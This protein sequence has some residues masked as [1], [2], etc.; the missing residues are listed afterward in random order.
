MLNVKI[1]LRTPINTKGM[2]LR[3]PLASE[4]PVTRLPPPA[5]PSPTGGSTDA[6]TFKA[7]QARRRQAIIRARRWKRLTFIA[8]VAAAAAFHFW[9]KPQLAP[10]P[11]AQTAA[12]VPVPVPVPVPDPVV[13]PTAAPAATESPAPTTTTTAARTQSP[14][15]LCADHFSARRWRAAI[16]TCKEA[17]ASTPDAQVALML[18]HSH[19]ARG[20]VAS[21]GRWASRAVALGTRDAD[22]YVIIGHAER[23]AGNHQQAVRAYRRYLKASPQGWHARNVRAA[24]RD[25]RA[26]ALSRAAAVLPIGFLVL[27]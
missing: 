5:T 20:K 21:G 7:M 13:A 12:G 3:S 10:T 27:R 2:D 1:V 22:A 26:K 19:Y 11:A 17:F 16:D 24:L 8:L 4:L 25:L 18:A 15:I 23:Q 6:R 14:A 9:W